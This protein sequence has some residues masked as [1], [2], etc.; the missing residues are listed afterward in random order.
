LIASPAAGLYQVVF[1][2]EPLKN[3]VWRDAKTGLAMLPAGIRPRSAASDVLGSESLREFLEQKCTDYDLVVLD[4]PPLVG[5]VDLRAVAPAVDVFVLVIAWGKTPRD[6]VVR[7]LS[8][9][10]LVLQRAVGCVLNRVNMQALPDYD[11]DGS[12]YGIA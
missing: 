9:V 12:R 11:R 3:V 8:T 10:D 5:S 7:T 2:E 6:V 1:G 4:L